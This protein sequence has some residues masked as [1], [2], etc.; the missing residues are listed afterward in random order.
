MTRPEYMLEYCWNEFTEDIAYRLQHCRTNL[1][2]NVSD[3]TLR[4]Y[5][6]IEIENILQSNNKSLS[7][8]P[9]MPIPIR[10]MADVTVNGL[11]LDE[12]DYNVDAMREELKK[13]LSF[14]SYD[15][16]KVFDDIME[17]VIND[18][19]GLFFLYVHGGTRLNFIWKTL[20]TH[21]RSKGKTVINVAYSVIASLLLPGGRTVH[22]KFGLPIIVHESL[23]CNI[24]PQSPH[25]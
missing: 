24:K 11:V 14:I 18:R 20:S 2:P 13:Y 15:Q 10:S 9:P 6:L 12:L 8:F 7:N 4:N 5:A 23:T 3:D 1:G 16:K 25:A 22:S 19:G 21:I 17:V